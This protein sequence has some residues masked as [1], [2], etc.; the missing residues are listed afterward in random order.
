[1]ELHAAN[2]SPD[3]ACGLVAGRNSEVEFFYPLTNVATEADRYVV[4]PVGHVRALRHAERSGWC[5][6]GVFHSHPGGRA[7]LSVRDIEEANEPDWV[8][9]VAG[10]D[11]VRAW[12]LAGRTPV[13]VDIDVK[14]PLRS[15]TATLRRHA[16]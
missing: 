14:E 1:M 10:S 9:F 11:G 16:G 7:E 13:E 8:Y 12:V 6:T 5:L 4:D 3:E 2:E 15:A